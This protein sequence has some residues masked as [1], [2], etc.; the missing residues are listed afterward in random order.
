MSLGEQ[1]LRPAFA[2]RRGTRVTEVTGARAPAR[3][4]GRSSAK[5]ER[6]RRQERE[7]REYSSS[8]SP[9]TLHGWCSGCCTVNMFIFAAGTSCTRGTSRR[10]HR[11]WVGYPHINLC[12]LKFDKPHYS[13]LATLANRPDVHPFL[14]LLYQGLFQSPDFGVVR[15]FHLVGEHHLGVPAGGNVQIPFFQ[16]GLV[17]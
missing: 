10:D 8:P 17:G 15:V 6:L 2:G 14:S 4:E 11:E 1:P 7:R 5:R 12:H 3:A 16:A 9:E 13:S